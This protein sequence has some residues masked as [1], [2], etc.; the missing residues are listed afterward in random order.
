MVRTGPEEI[1]LA[2]APLDASGDDARQLAESFRLDLTDALAQ[3]PHVEVRAAH[4]VNQLHLTDASYP[5]YS[6]KLGLDFLLFGQ[7]SVVGRVCQLQFEL[8][9]GKDA[10]HIATFHYSGTVDQLGSIRDEIQQ[11]VFTKLQIAGTNGGH[12]RGSTSDPEAYELYLQAKYHFSLQ[13][14][15][16]L[17]QAV[18]E[19]RS[20]IERDPNFAKAY[21]GLAQTQ[22]IRVSDAYITPQEGFKQAS[23]AVDK[24]RALDQSSAQVHS[25]LGFIRFYRDW[26]FAG[27]IDEDRQ[28]VR[29]DPHQAIYH[30]WLSVLLCDAG[31]YREAIS[32]IGIAQ[33]DDP[34]WP[35]LY[36]TEAYIA[37]NARDYKRMLA[38]AR[39]LKELLPESTKPYDVM[40]N[41]LWYSGQYEQGIAEWRRMAVLQGDQERVRM[42]DAGL[43][44]FRKGGVPAYAKI[45]IRAFSGSDE[46][47]RDPSDFDPFEWYMAAG[48]HKAAIAILKAKVAN[49][50]HVLFEML[51]G[52]FSDPI[53]SDPH[54]QTI[55]STPGLPTLKAGRFI[56]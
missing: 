30:Q 47:V 38:A 48:D 9:R 28:A 22:L 36:T 46:P 21:V 52:P 18:K 19:Y 20:A 23:E 5:T 55:F 40:A 35:S 31:R 32:E 50:D 15:E 49:R 34:Y 11:D 54:F 14:P 43:E 13:T 33:S 24:A 37:L 16:S 4:S 44:A 45:R 39:K 51:M 8:V 10:T 41:A 42:E 6:S 29:L 26:D 53:Y 56:P 12:P 25:I 7:F 17:S 27:A 1:S 3:L 2:V